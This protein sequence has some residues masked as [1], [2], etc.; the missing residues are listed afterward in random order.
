MQ[1]K[2]VI[3]VV[4]WNRLRKHLLQDMNEHFAFGLAGY[5]SIDHSYTL[6]VRDLVLVQDHDLVTGNSY[7][8]LSINLEMLLD[9]MNKANREDLV[10]VEAHSH[11]FSQNSVGFSSLDLSGQRELFTHLQDVSPR[12]PYA[13]VVFGQQAVAGLLWLPT[14]KRPSPIQ[15]IRI[16]TDSIQ[17]I[18]AARERLG[19]KHAESMNTEPYGTHSTYH[20]QVLA[21]GDK[22]QYQL[23]QITVG[24]VGLGGIGSIVALE[25]AHLGV[26]QFILVDD[27]AVE[28]TNLNRLVGATT[29]DVGKPKQ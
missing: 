1:N 21:F 10:I 7:Y 13:A 26:K 8:G 19:N 3:P 23:G 5:A 12:K 20:R 18:C 27:D 4:T 11:P 15:E 29:K 24:I 2:L 28:T 16:P 17:R 14:K 6:L 25:L 9:V 22:G